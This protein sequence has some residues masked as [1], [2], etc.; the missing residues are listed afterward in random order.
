[1][2]IV[3]EFTIPPTALPAGDTLVD[4]PAMRIEIER[5]VPS[6]DSALPFFWVWGPEPDEFMKHA[7][8]EPNM[9][10]IDV[11]DRVEDGA[12]FRAEWTPSAELIQGIKHL[13]AVIIEAIGTSDQW[14]F[15]I[16]TQE[17]AAFTRFQE[18]FEQQ[19]V[20]VRLNRIYDFSDLV[21][22]DVGPLTP[23][24]RE[25]LLA[26]Y[27]EGYFGQ[28]RETTQEELADHFDV[29]RRAIS[30][31]LRRGIRNLIASSLVSAEEQH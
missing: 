31:R 2:S 1:M 8:Q 22:G 20:S 15:E 12:L 23:A 26:A 25:T 21:E 29:T 5:I 4:N 18:L 30:D 10:E 9:T 28:P 16:R 11:L 7:E 24:Q 19:G 3:A 6:E 27:R 13:D 17:R 14:R